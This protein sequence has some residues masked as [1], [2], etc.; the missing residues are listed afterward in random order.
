MKNKIGVLIPAR[1]ESNR[2]PG[3]PLRELNGK[4]ILERTYNQ[5]AKVVDKKHIYILTDSKK[6]LQNLQHKIS[7]IIL[8]TG[9]YY[10]GT[11]RCARNFKKIKKNYSGY[12]IVSCDFPYI[13]TN[14][15]VETIKNF[16]KISNKKEYVGSTIHTTSKDKKIIYSKKIP[17]IVLNNNNDIIYFSRSPIPSNYKLKVDYNV[18]HGI[19]CLKP[20]AFNLFINLKNNKLARSEENEWLQFIE[21]GYKIKSSKVKKISREINDK[22]DL[23]FYKKN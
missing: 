6:I 5:V 21:N 14:C 3:K 23:K 4:S 1:L 9:N 2:L 12:L 15:I 20:Q 18:H 22:E 13:S 19:V 17:K 7:N 8:T 10:S 16:R 11:E